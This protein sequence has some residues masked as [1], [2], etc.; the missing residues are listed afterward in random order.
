LHKEEPKKV[1]A[2]AIARLTKGLF[3]FFHFFLDKKVEQK[4]KK[5]ANAPL[6]FPGPRTGQES[7]HLGSYFDSEVAAL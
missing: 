6:L 3:S 4:V 1:P 7:Y 2:A 5:K